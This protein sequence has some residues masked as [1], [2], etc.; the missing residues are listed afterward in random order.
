LVNRQGFEAISKYQFVI[1][2]R[3]ALKTLTLKNEENNLSM[4]S[5][6]WK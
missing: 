1:K 5:T 3:V 2:S 6:K 4:F